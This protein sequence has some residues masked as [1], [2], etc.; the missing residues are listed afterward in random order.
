MKIYEASA[1]IGL[2]KSERHSP[3]YVRQFCRKIHLFLNRNSKNGTPELVSML[4][5]IRKTQ[6][7]NPE[8]LVKDSRI[9]ELDE[10]VAE[11]KSSEEWEA[12]QMNILEIGI[13]HGMQKGLLQGANE[14]LT[15]LVEK[16]LKKGLSV[17]EIAELL[18][19][20]E[21][22]ISK[23]VEELQKK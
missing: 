11:V 15:E 8:I 20:P 3:F 17:A 13:E 22:V 19:E 23:I 5:Y 10:I 7:D 4:Q 9:L 16:K 12:V 1:I 6:I 21:D 18:E 2:H 14:K